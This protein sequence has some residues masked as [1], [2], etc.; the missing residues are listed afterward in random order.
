MELSYMSGPTMRALT[1]FLATVAG[2]VV[3]LSP[4]VSVA[5]LLSGAESVTLVREPQ[6]TPDG[7]GC[8]NLNGLQFA[9]PAA[10]IDLVQ[11]PVANNQGDAQITY[12]LSVPPGRAGLQ[13]NLALTYSSAGGNGWVGLGWDLS[14]GEVTIDTRWGVPRYDGTKE[15]E[16]YVLEGE[17]LAPTAVRSTPLDRETDRI[18]KRRIEGEFER[19]QRHGSAPGSYWWEVT[20]KSGKR[21]FYGGTPEGGRDNDAILADNNGNGFRWALKQIRDISNNTV[22]FNY[23]TV[24]G[25][26]VGANNVAIGQELYLDSILYNGTVA[27]GLPDDPAYEV[28]FVRASHLNES[29]RPDVSI[30]ARGGFLRVT[31]DLLR[32]VEV[33]YRGSLVRRFVLNYSEAAFSKMLLQSVGQT[34][35]DG[36]VF[37]SH[38]FDYYDDV[39]PGGSTYQGFETGSIWDTGDDG[40]GD[41]SASALGGAEALGADGRAYIG[42]NP[43]K[44]DKNGSFGGA[45]VFKGEEGMSR[46]EL[47]DIN[48]DNLPDKVFEDENQLVYRLNTSGPGG[49]T[50]FGLKR[51]V[52]G[53][54]NLSRESSFVFAVGP[55]AYFGIS[56]MYNHAWAWSWGK[57]YFIDVNID[58]LVDFVDNGTVYF[59]SLDAGGNPVFTMDSSNTGVPIDAGL[60]D[61]SAL[62]DFSDIE[63]RQREQAP[64]Q[65][66][67]RRWRAPWTGQVS[68]QGDVQ[69]LPPNGGFAGDGVRVAIQHEGA[70][71]WAA[72]IDGT[73]HAAKTPT[74]VSNITVSR[75][76]DIYFRVQSRDDGASDEVS[77]DPLITYLGVTP[78]PDV[79]GLDVHR[80]QASEDFTL[81]GRTDIFAIAPLDGTVRVTG[82]FTKSRKTTDDI[83]IQVFKNGAIVGLPTT[84]GRDETGTTPITIEFDVLST[85]QVLLRL[86]IDSP[87]DIAAFSWT[88]RLF[89]LSATQNGQPLT[90]TD[91]D[92]NPT[93]DLN[94]P[95]DIQMYPR[96]DLVVPQATWTAP[97]TANV[98]LKT[99][100]EF[101]DPEDGFV[102]VTVKKK[103]AQAAGDP[104]AELVAKQILEIQDGSVVG[105]PGSLLVSVEKDA[106]YW[107]DLSVAQP[108]LGSAWRLATIT[109][110]IDN[111]LVP[112]ARHWAF[113][114]ED[115]FPQPY[116]GWGFAGY[117]G[118]GDLAAS[119][120]VENNLLFDENDYPHASPELIDPSNEFPT[121]DDVDPNYQNPVQGKACVYAP[122]VG[123]DE[124]T[125][126]E[127]RQWRGLKDNI[128]GSAVGASSSRIGPDSIGLPG[129]GDLPGARAVTRFSL[130]EADAIAGGVGGLVGGSFAWGTS[131][132]ILDFFDMNGD[133][134]PDI[135]GNGGVQYTTARG[136]LESTSTSLSKL[137]DNI[138][139]DSSTSKTLNGGGTAAEIKADSKGDANTSQD[140][141]PASGQRKRSSSSNGDTG[142]ADSGDDSQT[143]VSLGLSGDLGWASTNTSNDSPLDDLLESELA[144][145]NGDGLPDRIRV[146]K[147]GRITVSFNIGYDFDS[148][149]VDWP[150]GSFEQGQ[151]DS[152]SV[153]PSLGFSTGNLS[154]SGGVSLSSSDEESLST[155]VDLNGD[156]LLDQLRIS[157]DDVVVR[158]GTGAG[159]TGDIDWGTFRE[160]AIARSESIGLGGGVDFTIGIGPLCKGGCYI[161]IN[162]GGH[163]EGGMSR[164]ELELNDVNGDGY[165]DHIASTSDESMDVSLNTTGRTNLLKSVANPLGGTIEFDYTRKGNTTSQAFSQ[166]VM[167]RVAVDDGR[168]GDGPDVRLTT[169]KYEDNVYHALE[170]NFLGYAT[171]TEQQRDAS[172]AG[173]PVLRSFER[174]YRNAT[175]FDSGLLERKTLLGPDGAIKETVNEWSFVDV[176][177]GT[178]ADLNLDPA[179]VGLLGLTVFPQRVKTEQRWYSGGTIVKRTWNTFAYDA[180]GN[181]VETV[182]VGEP[183]LADDDVVAITTYTD[184]TSSTWVSLPDSFEIRNATGDVLRTR[185]A[186]LLC[187]NG[188]VTKLWEDTTGNGDEALTEL[189][190][191]AYGNYDYIIYP[192]NADGERY[193]VTYVYDADRHTNIAQVVD[194][195]GLIGTATY[196]GPTGQ[197]ASQTDANGQTTSYTYDLQGRL[198]SITGPYEQGTGNAMVTFEYF[199]TAPNYA[200]GLAHHYDMFHPA[201]TINTV[202]FIDG[203]GR[204]TQTKQDAT[205][206][207]GAS[208][209]AEDAMIV[210]GAVEF[211]ALGRAVKEWY[212]IEEPLGTIGTYNTNVDSVA[213]TLTSW[214]LTDLV[215]EVT[216][217]DGSITTTLYDFTLFLATRTDP[218][219]NDR[220]SYSDVR[221]NVLAVEVDHH[222]TGAAVETLRTSYTYDPLQQLVQVMDPG[223]N[224]T[225]HEYD[226]LGRRT[227]TTTPD[228]GRVELV[229]DLASQVIAKI[230]PNLRAAGG[231]ISYAY[232]FN[233]LVGISYTDGTPNVSYEYGGPGAPDNGAGRIVHVEDGARAQ[234]RAFD[235]LGEVVEETTTMFVH[236]LNDGTEEWLTWTTTSQFDTWRRPKTLTYP[237]GEVVSYGY[238]S[239]GLTASVVGNKAATAYPYV[240]RQEYDKFLARRFLETG[241]G[242]ASET[243]YDP[244]TR[245]LA[246]QIIDAPGRRVQD[247]TYTYDLVGNVLAADNAAPTPVPDLMGGTSQQMFI[248]DD[249]YRLVEATGNYDFAP[250]KRREYTYNL[251]YDN[252]GNIVQKSQTDT[253]FNNPPVG[254]PQHKTTYDQ[255]YDYFAAPHQPTHIGDQSYTYDDSGNLSG[256]TDDDSGQNRTVTLDAEDR[257]T[258]IAD[259]GSTTR[260]TYNDEDSLAIERGPEGE[261]SFVNRFYTVH[262]GTVTWKHF[263]AGTERIATKREMPEDEIEHMRY[264]FHK[265]LLGSTNIVTDPNGLVFEHI[266][267]FPSGETWVLEHSDIY[268]TPYLYSGGYFDEFRE[269]YNLGARWYEPREQLFYSP[270]PALVQSPRRPISDPAL[271]AAYTYAEDNPLR[272]VDRDGR[273][274]ED[275]LKAFRAEFSKP[276]GS[277]DPAKVRLFSALVQQ[278]VDERKFGKISRLVARVAAD[279]K[280]S[281]KSAFK[282]FATFSAKPVVQIN[283]KR[284]SD[285]LKLK[286]VKVAPFFFK[287]FTVKKGKP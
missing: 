55:E 70:E 76:D 121:L 11:P 90:V 120:V 250:S 222:D 65:D 25:S 198:A 127:V 263:W 81:G 30:D 246:R 172:T 211:D 44:G 235:R 101:R 72:F 199:P 212:P 40:V 201:D 67:L 286:N 27:D 232:D 188:A 182:D 69:L 114:P 243:R 153:G 216:A 117:N 159:L 60:V 165:P 207:R 15:T 122:F 218:L 177:T 248:Y 13:P 110:D 266:E 167:S 185:R 142:S 187:A 183:D 147:D 123:I 137:S 91:A 249:L 86:K 173:E 78:L 213:P 34:G 178:V 4:G 20:D 18:F 38:T 132:G 23:A 267:Y 93:L 109:I 245:R 75:G 49:T 227:A 85:D 258:S 63:D 16:T 163:I 37:A 283:L 17:V 145:I 105:T 61:A 287:Q 22:T 98:S 282:A 88:P 259:Q 186:E 234:S 236:N 251:V 43:Y 104:P 166:W 59:N 106:E 66:T 46:L 224:P 48:G 144:D 112:S 155:W 107:F 247:I 256:W 262:N 240:N 154:F 9:D 134:F 148:N 226:L 179:G 12:P 238:D 42:F 217:P 150:G 221:E 257:S 92:G 230:T 174:A 196:H 233:R 10:Q 28:R 278:Q 149:E 115:V 279:P 202:R 270:D 276:N 192:P 118:D 272:L 113:I 160:G 129:A 64:L 264:F 57:A 7:L 195:Y 146:Y 58:G 130:T 206:F 265:D 237:D 56:V 190:F 138:R 84:I 180:L 3:G 176:D 214:T 168:P 87:V 36:V 254:I 103:I 99:I 97:A 252:L 158:F 274:P 71:L 203:I 108:G 32:H 151:S 111:V 223:G 175:I 135:I 89:Y 156:G 14:V 277:L 208:Q 83:T 139:E 74:G 271:L 215:T 45:F 68:I 24:T 285:G 62:P 21:R 26:G 197:V 253:V 94:A 162:P 31:S 219:G 125:G 5:D 269:L 284:T 229:Y 268:R 96:T 157:N 119:P 50:T 189:D 161:I 1:F 39:R 193:E 29:R 41:S 102:V 200:Y 51:E 220:R 133:E 280:G 8:A 241:N 2:F 100:V 209:S 273:V 170:R 128:F 164:Q 181:I 242:V 244:A 255:I 205:V 143:G 47:L 275:V 33:Y 225:T 231:Q 140:I 73:D 260:Y 210:S 136:G 124:A 171:V 131:E 77:W 228:G 82:N 191:D 239:G 52:T 19:I 54:N 169:Y 35:S 194:S 204:E 79:N 184:C 116:R 95:V 152:V 53:V 281:A 126:T 141:V 261:T 6:Q 80:Y